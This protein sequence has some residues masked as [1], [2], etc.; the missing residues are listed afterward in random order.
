MCHSHQRIPRDIFVSIAINCS[1]S[2]HPGRHTVVLITDT[3]RYSSGC[4]A[5]NRYR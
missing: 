2:S 3:L 4:L 5:I 1:R